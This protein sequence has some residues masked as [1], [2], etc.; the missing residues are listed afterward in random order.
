MK[1]RFNINLDDSAFT[2]ERTPVS[3]SISMFLC[4]SLYNHLSQTCFFFFLPK[5]HFQPSTTVGQSKTNARSSPVKEGQPLSYAQYIIKAKAQGAV[6]LQRD[7]SNEMLTSE[8]GGAP[9]NARLRQSE[10]DAVPGMSGGDEMMKSEETQGSG[11]GQRDVNC[12]SLG[13]KPSGSGS[14]II[15]SPRQVCI[16]RNI[17]YVVTTVYEK[18]LAFPPACF[19][20]V[21]Q[22]WVEKLCRWL[23]CGFAINCIPN[24][25]YI[26]QS[27]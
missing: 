21:S 27:L 6:P 2:K 22:K 7:E 1:K 5:Q 18:Y 9:N 16:R 19:K 17:S 20:T 4:V 25:E 14:S 15:V 23:F 11:C 13:A 3:E 8:I 24:K 26:F 10:S 12:P